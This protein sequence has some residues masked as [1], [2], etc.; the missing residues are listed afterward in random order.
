MEKIEVLDNMDFE[1]E[2]QCNP[3][4]CHYDCIEPSGHC[5][6]NNWQGF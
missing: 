3:N 1:M 4:D 5:S 6:S 2:V